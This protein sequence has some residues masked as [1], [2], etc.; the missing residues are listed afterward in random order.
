VVQ[1]NGKLRDRLSVPAEISK[2]ELQDKA[3]DLD[4][5]KEMLVDK[6][7]VKVVTVPGNW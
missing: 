7:I 1:I 6:Q 4:K 5:V 3:M 2:E